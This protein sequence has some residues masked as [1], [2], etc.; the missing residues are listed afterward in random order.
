MDLYWPGKL[1]GCAE[2]A[3]QREAFACWMIT[4]DYVDGSHRGCFRT[5]DPAGADRTRVRQ[6]IEGAP[7]RLR[8]RMRRNGR[9]LYTGLYVGPI[10][11]QKLRE[12]LVM[13]GAPIGQCWDI[14]YLTDAG[15][16][17]R[18]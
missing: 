14:E 7:D 11:R 2:P 18:T 12:P 4:R 6:Q 1:D 10:N 9:T 15:K 5:H 17:E 16:W 8:F 3:R 13:V